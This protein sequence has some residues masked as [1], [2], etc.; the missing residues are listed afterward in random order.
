MCAAAALKW[1][2]ENWDD[3]AASRQ[4]YAALPIQ[5]AW[6][7]FG[8]RNRTM[9]TRLA[10]RGEAQEWAALMIQKHCRASVVRQLTKELRYQ[11]A[12]AEHSGQVQRPRHRTTPQQHHCHNSNNS[13]HRQQQS[14]NRLRR[15]LAVFGLRGRC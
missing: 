2:R 15:S 8:A 11:I 12:Q 9:E 10:R 3:S 14:K 5:K 1:I 13:Q 4:K 7:G 6:R